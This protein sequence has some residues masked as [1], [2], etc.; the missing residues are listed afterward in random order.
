MKRPNLKNEL[1][2]Y[3]LA[4]PGWHRKVQLYVVADNL[5]FSPESGA[6]KLRELAEEGKIKVEYYKGKWA[7]KLCKYTADDI[8]DTSNPKI[9][10]VEINGQRIAKFI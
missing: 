10:V 7:R 2:K 1:H 9:Q 6:R 5:G 8:P 4:N 3:L